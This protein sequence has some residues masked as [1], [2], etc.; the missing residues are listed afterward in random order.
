MVDSRKL[1]TVARHSLF[2]VIYI[3]YENL[4]AFIGGLG[5]NISSTLSA[6]AVNIADFYIFWACYQMLEKKIRKKTLLITA[7]VIV[8]IAIIAISAYLKVLLSMLILKQP[9]SVAGNNERAVAMSSRAIYFG[10]LGVAYGFFKQII[11][12][13]REAAQHRL[14]KAV[15][16]Q[17]QEKL[18]KQA[19]RAELSVIKSQINPHFIFNTLGFLYGETYKKLPEVGETIITLSNIMRH[20]LTKNE[21]GFSSLES[22][23]GYIKDFIKIH[24]ARSPNFFLSVNIDTVTR[25][26][27]IVSLV[28]ITL[29]ENMFK[30]GIFN[31]NTKKATLN[32]TINDGLLHFYSL[33]YKGGNSMNKIESNGIGLN[34]IKERLTE[35]Y[36][37][38]FELLINETH[39]SY[40]CKLVM[41][42]KYESN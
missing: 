40:E 27:K 13:E 7:I 12:K 10:T 42:L 17:Q 2:W 30:H 37:Q 11:L 16:L 23:L 18:E 1:K 24:A 6:F 20:A 38:N 25:P 41:P 15:M 8:S 32:I 4:A 19:L 33:N 14:E 39:N 21:D 28:L 26:Y 9:F 34:Y 5:I 3:C 22:E 35:E 31:Q 29:I 36:G